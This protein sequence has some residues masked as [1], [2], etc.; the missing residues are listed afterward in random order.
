MDQRSRRRELLGRLLQ[1][2]PFLPL[3][4]AGLLMLDWIEVV[5]VSVDTAA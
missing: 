3:L 5:V 4:D 2:H 1:R